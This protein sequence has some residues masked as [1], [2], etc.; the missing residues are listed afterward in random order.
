MHRLVIAV[1]VALLVAGAVAVAR[2]PER[3][4]P[5]AAPAARAEVVWAV[6]DAAGPGAAHDAVARLVARAPRLDRLLYLGDVYERGTAAEFRR[7]YAPRY[8][9]LARRTVPT[10]G[11]HEWPNRAEGFLPYWRA[12]RGGPQPT[13]H[14][15]RLG[16]WE[17]VALN[18]E[19][20][21]GPGS[22]QLRWLRRHLRGARGT[23][24]LAFWHR[25][26]ASAGTDHGDAPDVEPLRAALRGRVRLTVHGHEHSL[27]R[28]RPVDG[29][30]ALVVGAGGRP[31][32]P[33]RR[34]DPRLAWGTDAHD[35]ALRLELAPGR[36][37][38]AFVA[39]D[40]R[41]L[42]AGTVRCRV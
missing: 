11:N 28:L 23:C 42:D 22:A 19:A 30:T 3:A 17:L 34:D 24:R 6:G 15:V 8:G 40:G 20:P 41:V 10:P 29:A 36:A 5:A 39:V 21:H 12:V 14:A 38:F 4:R 25:P 31:R 7:W 16:G 33:L 37:R 18:S 2:G 35:G 9:A 13:H 32:D 1:A 27:Q 26:R